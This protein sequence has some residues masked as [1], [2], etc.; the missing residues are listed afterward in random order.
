M[1]RSYFFRFYKSAWVHRPEI[2]VANWGGRTTKN[3][4]AEFRPISEIIGKIRKLQNCMVILLSVKMT[5]TDDFLGCR[6]VLEPRYRSMKYLN[7]R[8][9]QLSLKIFFQ[10]CFQRLMLR[11]EVHTSCNFHEKY[12][13]ILEYPC[14][15]IILF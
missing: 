10:K 5:A 7:F 15:D 4:M 8:P 14:I 13:C 3:R 12:Q 1:S 2:L 6:R 11:K 9:V